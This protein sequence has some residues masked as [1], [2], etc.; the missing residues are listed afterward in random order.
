MVSKC[1]LEA[2]HI[3]IQTVIMERI[4]NEVLNLSKSVG[5]EKYERIKATQARGI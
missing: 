5:H 4:I 1:I 2:S 3:E